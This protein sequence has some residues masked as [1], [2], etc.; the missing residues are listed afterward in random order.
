MTGA[1]WTSAVASLLL[2]VFVASGASSC[3]TTTGGTPSE[4]SGATEVTFTVTGSTTAGVDITYGS[5]SSNFQ[6]PQEPPMS[7]TLQIDEHALYYAVNA[8][9]Q[10]GGDVTCEIQIGDVV[11]TGHARGGYNIC[12]A[13]LNKDFNGGWG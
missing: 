9:L 13:Q 1:R 11:R 5:D 3:G 4:G 10:G 6:G 7:E 8:Q 2:V 12:S